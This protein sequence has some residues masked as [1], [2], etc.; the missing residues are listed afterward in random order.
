MYQS[1]VH[2]IDGVE[3]AAADGPV[4]PVVN[5]ATEER[6]GEG[7]AAGPAQVAAA[8][9]AAGRGLAGW[10][11]ASPWER[12]RVLRETGRLMRER[13]E[14]LALLLPL[15]VGKPLAEARAEVA[16][17]AEHFDWCAAEARRI[18]GLSPHRPTQR[19]PFPVPP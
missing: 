18:Y 12:A 15:E 3:T 16:V 10:R 14:E 13:E 6:L 7:V 17:S 19:P 1:P 8:L 2:F 11:A 5:P 9:Q 4:I